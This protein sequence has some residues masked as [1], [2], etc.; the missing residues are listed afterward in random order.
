MPEHGRRFLP[1][2][3]YPGV[4]VTA[5]VLQVVLLRA[6]LPIGTSSY[7]AVVFG[8]V[9][10]MLLEFVIPYDRS[11]QPNKDDVKNDLMFMVLV[12]IVLPP[13]L[14]LFFGIT[15]IRFLQ[16]LNVSMT[17]W[18]PGDLPIV[19]QVV[20]MLLVAEFFRYWLHV[21]AHNTQLWRLHAVHHSP[22]KLYWL[23]VGRF[24]PV[25]KALQYLLDAL[26]FILVGVGEQVFTGYFIFYAVNGFFQHSNVDA[27]Y[28]IL[29]YIVS[30]AELH[31]WHHSK[32]I[33]ESNNNYGNNFIVWDLV[34]RSWFLPRDRRVGDLGLL[35]PDYPL[36]FVS[37][38]TTPLKPGL[39]KQGA[40][41]NAS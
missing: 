4:V 37:Q 20:L 1:W 30:G 11:W 18:W 24:H 38:L 9:A 35:N 2:L 27:R 28:G 7:I 29:N 40:A 39:D 17:A 22:K 23:N 19:V 5:F 41:S 8:A 3:V 32:R 36:D 21:A 25:E 12:Q 33:E 13:L 14:T 10:V 34:F 15:L 26:P 31:R 16:T 6:G